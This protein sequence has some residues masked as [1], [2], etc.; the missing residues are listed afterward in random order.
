MRGRRA[1]VPHSSVVRE[2]VPH[3][4][5]MV[6]RNERGTSIKSFSLVNAPGSVQLRHELIQSVAVLNGADGPWRS[7]ETCLRARSSA[8]RLLTFAE[9][10]GIQSLRELSPDVWSRFVAS[11]NAGGQKT[12]YKNLVV[13]QVRRLVLA[14]PATPARTRLRAAERYFTQPRDVQPQRFHT[15]EEFDRIKAAAMRELRRAVAR[16][17]RANDL[18]RGD[19]GAGDETIAR[20]KAMEDFLAGAIPHPVRNEKG[21][22]A[23]GYQTKAAAL[24]REVAAELMPTGPEIFAALI[25]L[26]CVSGD[27]LSTA[28]N[29]VVPKTGASS[30]DDR[31]TVLSTHLDKPR[32]GHRRHMPEHVDSTSAKG[33]V[34]ALIVEL[35][36]AARRRAAV[37]QPELEDCLFLWWSSARLRFDLMGWSVTYMRESA[38]WAQGLPHF[39]T[40]SLHR[41]YITRISQSAHHQTL[42]TRA[43]SYL[44]QDPDVVARWESITREGVDRLF[45][46]A[47]ESTELLLERSREGV[48]SPS[49]RQEL[50]TPSGMVC[51]DPQSHPTSRRICRDPFLACLGCANAYAYEEHVPILVYLHRRLE[52]ERSGGDSETWKSRFQLPWAQLTAILRDLPAEEW[53][54]ADLALTEAGKQLVERAVFERRWDC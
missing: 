38:L 7:Q 11:V 3:G 41:T 46:D 28:Q 36:E 50:V 48:H 6:V 49:E 45:Q 14:S 13:S 53:H 1:I 26:I 54:A 40:A 23:N 42:Q 52:Q 8:Q 31:M 12:R 21:R 24:G 25:A 43:D 44:R 20:R 19:A 51:R 16:V 9:E 18:A 39:T 37:D 27:N 5:S 4:L 30:A 15:R 2:Q 29:R 34:L 33:E 47:L 32:R 10:V 35:T 17:S 22:L